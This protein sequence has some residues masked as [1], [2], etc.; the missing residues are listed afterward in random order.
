[1][2]SLS[3]PPTSKSSSTTIEIKNLKEQVNKK[4]D[5]IWTKDMLNIHRERIDETKEIALNVKNKFDNRHCLQQETIREMRK[6]IQ[7]MKNIKFLASLSFLVIIGG[8]LF[9]FFSLKN[10]ADNNQKAVVTV[11]ESVKKIEVDVKN[12]TNA[13]ESHIENS[14]KTK[15]EEEEK[16]QELLEDISQVVKVE[17]KRSRRI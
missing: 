11:Q 12:V 16:R 17:I 4:A 13:V 10:T 7:S 15:T 5:E 3:S 14:K 9:Q 6:T 8:G 1:M 2:N